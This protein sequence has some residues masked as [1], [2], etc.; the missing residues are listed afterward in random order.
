MAQF[1]PTLPQVLT[2]QSGNS[3]SMERAIKQIK[4]L[5]ETGAFLES[6]QDRVEASIDACDIMLTSIHLGRKGAA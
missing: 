6:D 4:E 2:A 5:L 3:L 1:S